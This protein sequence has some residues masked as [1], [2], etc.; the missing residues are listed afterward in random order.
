MNAATPSATSW[1]K[2]VLAPVVLVSGAEGLLVD[3]AVAQL[4]EQAVFANPELERTTVDAAAYQGGNLEVLTSPSLF[5]EPRFIVIDNVQACTDPLIPDVIA[6]LGSTEPDV[7]LVLVH[8]GGVRGKKLLDAL[9]AAK[10][11]RVV[12]DAIKKDADKAQFVASEFKRSKRR[13]SSDAVDM[14]VQAVGSDLRELAAAC[15]QLI[16]DTEGMVDLTSVERYYGGRVEVSSFRV[17]DAAVAGQPAAAIVALRHALATGSDPVPLV[18]ALAS[19]L[20]TLA[21]VASHA[22]SP[23]S[24]AKDLGLAPWQV[25]RSRRDLRHWTPTGLAEAIVLTARAD[26]EVK[27]MSRDP[28]FAVERAVLAVA[29]RA[30]AQARR[31]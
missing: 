19:K 22:G 1:D 4:R 11:P 7:Y 9:K 25:E 18:G 13:A 31:R 21:L 26:A 23:A 27:G 3:R 5:G 29:A 12:C 24:A 2:A 20:R 30:G 8:R 28:V 10:V 14:L 17:A 15:A 16:N 6:Y